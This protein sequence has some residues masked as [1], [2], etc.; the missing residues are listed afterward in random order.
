VKLSKKQRELLEEFAKLDDQES[1]PESAGFF[2]KVKE[3]LGGKS[4]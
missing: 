2:D 3:M 4:E 1:S